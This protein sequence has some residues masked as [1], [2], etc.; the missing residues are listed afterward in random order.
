MG[1]KENLVGAKATDK[2]LVVMLKGVTRISWQPFSETPWSPEGL[3]LDPEK[4]VV[5]QSHT[6]RPPV[7]GNP[8]STRKR[9]S[10]QKAMP[11]D[12]PHRA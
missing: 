1:T 6:P 8:V 10:F 3:P 2:R 7:R 5:S 4:T 9:Q 12:P 11:Q